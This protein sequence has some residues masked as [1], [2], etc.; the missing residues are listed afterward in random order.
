MKDISAA[1][2]S[3]PPSDLIARSTFSIYKRHAKKFFLVRASTQRSSTTSRA[4]THEEHAARIKVSGR[5]H[6]PPASTRSTCPPR[7]RDQERSIFEMDSYTGKQSIFYCFF[8]SINP[9]IRSLYHFLAAR[10]KLIYFLGTSPFLTIE[11]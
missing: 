11:L 5:P 4:C 3:L 2:Y 7:A 6:S 9:S 8:S 10:I 1:T